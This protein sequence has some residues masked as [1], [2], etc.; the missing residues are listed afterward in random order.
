ML[1]LAG[2]ILEA[3][4]G[5]LSHGRD[6][7]HGH[8]SIEGSTSSQNVLFPG[9][10]SYHVR[11]AWS[12]M[13][14]QAKDGIARVAYETIDSALSKDVVWQTVRESQATCKRTVIFFSPVELALVASAGP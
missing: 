1:W 5:L 13:R 9:S 2:S 10:T 11:L 14:T 3:L 8:Q 12:C 6:V 4:P 7:Q